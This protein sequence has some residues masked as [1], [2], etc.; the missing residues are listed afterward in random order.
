MID[1]L[2]VEEKAALRNM[3]HKDKEESFGFEG[4]PIALVLAGAFLGREQH[5]GFQTLQW[6]IR[7]QFEVAKDLLQNR[8]TD[9]AGEDT[10]NEITG[11]GTNPIKQE[12][13]YQLLNKT[14]T[15]M[16]ATAAGVKQAASVG[17]GVGA[18]GSK[19]SVAVNAQR[20][21]T[22]TGTAIATGTSSGIAG[23]SGEVQIAAKAHTESPV[24]SID[25]N[26]RASIDGQ[27]GG[28][29]QSATAQKGEASQSATAQKGKPGKAAPTADELELE[30]IRKLSV[31]R[32]VLVVAAWML[33]YSGS[34][35]TTTLRDIFDTLSC[36]NLAYIS[37]TVVLR[38]IA[39]QLCIHG[40]ELDDAVSDMVDRDLVQRFRL[41]AVHR[42]KPED[43]YSIHPLAV[44]IVRRSPE[45]FRKSLF[46]ALEAVL[47]LS[48]IWSEFGTWAALTL[49]GAH[50][51]M[52]LLPHIN[53]LV[54]FIESLEE[55]SEPERALLLSAHI[56]SAHAE[57]VLCS[58]H[59]AISHLEKAIA[60]LSLHTDTASSSSCALTTCHQLLAEVLEQTGKLPSALEHAL[61]A[62][63]RD[64]ASITWDHSATAAGLVAVRVYIRTQRGEAAN[65]LIDEMLRATNLDAYTRAKIYRHR[66]GSL[67]ATLKY[68]AG[69]VSG[70][71][72]VRVL[73]DAQGAIEG[74]QATRTKLHAELI[75]ANRSVLGVLDILGRHDD[76]V[77]HAQ[78]LLALLDSNPV[79]SYTPDCWCLLSRHAVAQNQWRRGQ[80]ADAVETLALATAFHEH[81]YGPRAAHHLHLRTLCQLGNVHLSNRN[82]GGALETFN[83]AVTV[84]HQMYGTSGSN[85]YYARIL[86]GVSQVFAL[87]NDVESAHGQLV[88]AI[89]MLDKIPST[90]HVLPTALD[91]LGNVLALE[92]KCGEALETIH[93]A[94]AKK[95][96][97][98]GEA[99][100]HPE[101]ACSLYLLGFTCYLNENVTEALQHLELALA[102]QQQCYSLTA[103]HPD[104]IQTV[105][106]MAECNGAR[107]DFKTGVAHCDRAIELAH[108][109]FDGQGS[110]TTTHP[111]VA[112][113]QGLRTQ[114]AKGRPPRQT[115]SANT[116]M[117]LRRLVPYFTGRERD[118]D[119]MYT[120]LN[121]DEEGYDFRP[122]R[123]V[124]ASD[125]PG[126]GKTQL[127][128][129]YC[130]DNR[131]DYI[132]G[133]H[134]ID[135]SSSSALWAGTVGLLQKLGMDVSA[136]HTT[137]QQLA[138][139]LFAAL[140]KVGSNWLLCFDGL[141]AG[142]ALEIFKSDYIV[143]HSPRTIKGHLAVTTSEVSETVWQTMQMGAPWIVEPMTNEDAAVLL[144]RLSR[145]IINTNRV[146]IRKIM[147]ALNEKESEALRFVAADSD[148]G[149]CAHPVSLV[150]AGHYIFGQGMK[151][152]SF[153]AFKKELR[154]S[155][156]SFRPSF[157]TLRS[158]KHALA[159]GVVVALTRQQMSPFANRV[160]MAM[161]RACPIE[162]SEP[163]LREFARALWV[164]RQK[165]DA[166]FFTGDVSSSTHSAKIDSELNSSTT[167]LVENHVAKPALLP[168]SGSSD[169]KNGE[170]PIVFVD[171]Y[172]DADAIFSEHV[173]DELVDSTALLEHVKGSPGGHGDRLI[174]HPCIH[175]VVEQNTVK[176]SELTM[177]ISAVVKGLPVVEEI[178]TRQSVA[179]QDSLAWAHSQHASHICQSADLQRVLLDAA[180]PPSD[181][182]PMLTF[183]GWIDLHTGMARSA[184][185]LKDMALQWCM[186][187]NDANADLS[188]TVRLSQVMARYF[189]AVVAVQTGDFSG[190]YKELGAAA[191]VSLPE[192]HHLSFELELSRATV[193]LQS[194]ESASL[195]AIGSPAEVQAHLMRAEALLLQYRT[196]AGSQCSS[197]YFQ[198]TLTFWQGAALQS[199]RPQECHARLRDCRKLYAATPFS[200]KGRPIFKLT[201]I[202]E[203][204]ILTR[205]GQ[206]CQAMGHLRKAIG[207]YADANRMDRTRGARLFVDL[208]YPKVLMCT[209][210]AQTTLGH[211]P[212]AIA[213]LEE[214]LRSC[215]GAV[216]ANEDDLEAMLA[217]IHYRLGQVHSLYPK[218]TLALKHQQEALKLRRRLVTKQHAT[219]TAESF[220]AMAEL[221]AC[222]ASLD[223]DFA[224]ML[225]ESCDL[226]LQLATK[227][228]GWPQLA[229]TFAQ[230]RSSGR[231][232]FLQGHDEKA[233]T[234]LTACKKQVAA[235]EGRRL[236]AASICLDLAEVCLY[237]DSPP[238]ANA[239]ILEALVFLTCK[240]GSDDSD[241]SDGGD[242]DGDGDNE[243][244]AQNTL[245]YNLV[246]SDGNNA[247]NAHAKYCRSY[248]TVRALELGG[249]AQELAGDLDAAL[250]WYSAAFQLLR[251][252]QQETH[253]GMANCLAKIGLVTRARHPQDNSGD[254]YMHKA[255]AIFSVIYGQNKMPSSMLA[256]RVAVWHGEVAEAAGESHRALNEYQRALSLAQKARPRSTAFWLANIY[257]KIG[258]ALEAIGNFDAAVAQYRICVQHACQTK[259]WDSVCAHQLSLGKMVDG[260]ACRCLSYLQLRVVRV[261]RSCPL[262]LLFRRRSLGL[263][264]D[265]CTTPV[266][267][268]VC[269]GIALA[270]ASQAPDAIAVL[271]SR[272]AIYWR[273]PITNYCF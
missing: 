141:V 268:C 210:T 61:D 125:V 32:Q 112:R 230:L 30:E 42:A 41:V 226:R 134:W 3:A 120:A 68:E 148:L 150:V 232:A 128:L 255:K 181:L 102:M 107:G 179:T 69:L 269:E 193:M 250:Q 33:N 13:F 175:A 194:M 216:A 203:P 266:H 23:P 55:L 127:L 37:R 149:L 85:E 240:A 206:A 229:G 261:P 53:R 242:S 219:H 158:P 172:A 249:D 213:T 126:S 259:R 223:D 57:R 5:G 155:K 71:E 51:V 14:E 161:N 260:V 136:T 82:I 146:G 99:S 243:D 58:P 248:H 50:Q 220:E 168:Q 40:A 11:G 159:L 38:V 110:S 254:A 27:E 6:Q 90:V 264:A 251:A 109:A 52:R 48:Q 10:F 165:R 101:I 188:E 19:P 49:S 95:R 270:K 96:L 130:F 258:S 177:L 144:M 80:Y 227:C 234:D 225:E 253:P 67:V 208:H 72:A 267:V 215:S 184:E 200:L 263:D 204:M 78:N 217:A 88:R 31:Q 143:E 176:A 133:I 89:A 105:A 129:R 97:L 246:A 154:R 36:L 271:N 237:Q 54:A 214:A 62:M 8:K 131:H 46:V 77:P 122:G 2:P 262:P 91:H 104:I 29:P 20:P 86:I 202:S 140:E 47:A 178:P 152:G 238:Q 173:L 28:A 39:T 211:F 116:H 228:A 98:F 187:Q 124:I 196:F 239:H 180:A 197:L 79:T 44:R 201:E 209:A 160:F 241:D 224:E 207:L 18:V 121:E 87:Q 189:A 185:I 119:Q 222:D 43:F 142:D 182:V 147:E 192:N 138:E 205:L 157:S 218:F 162:T 24:G 235:E 7:H 70:L 199:L 183:L 73:V 166:K 257:Y 198:A 59:G 153:R 117:W 74:A 273:Q 103:H 25:I 256:A 118:L 65:T 167:A 113:L 64:V 145:G 244:P 108:I 164:N 171:I 114:L 76:A 115:T 56:A 66:V 151:C 9:Q 34:I 75:L 63:Q 174:L 190:A 12:E 252:Q 60:L 21:S 17:S 212:A 195:S 139:A 1:K 123:V 245:I 272:C 92:R 22:G 100:H 4:Y 137:S 132:H 186:K 111:E 221:L 94:L 169:Q 83:H 26:T 16:G 135:A 15:H 170:E 106:L 35:L 191:T 156:R 93:S 163:V 236:D 247:S 45:E 84:A 233:Y 265:I 231:I 81:T